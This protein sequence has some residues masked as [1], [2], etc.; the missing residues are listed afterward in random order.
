MQ[1][2]SYD[3]Q[4]IEVGMFR[5]E[6]AMY[7]QAGGR[8]RKYSCFQVSFAGSL[9]LLEK[10]KSIKTEHLAL[11]LPVVG[12]HRMWPQHFLLS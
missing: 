9:K 5:V 3:K 7:V 10:T 11:C 6:E 2:N 1:F 8:Y 4:A 12:A